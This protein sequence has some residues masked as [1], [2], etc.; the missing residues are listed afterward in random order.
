MK[1]LANIKTRPLNKEEF[2]LIIKTIREGFVLP[3]NTRVKPNCRISN[4]L[5][6]EGSLGM[7]IGDVLR[8]KLENIIWDGDKYRLNI[9][10]EKTGKK[11]TFPVPTDFYIYLQNY[12]LQ[13]GIKPNQRLFNLTVR[14]VQHHLSL[15]C[16]Y[17]GL[18]GISTHSF[19]KYFSMSVY[20]NSNHNLELVRQLLMH[21]NC[22]ITT[23]Y[24]NISSKE[25]EDALN[26]H[27]T[28][29]A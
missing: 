7:R 3:G 13:N 5:F 1:K 23:A 29:P 10:E 6:V 18:S 9:T 22:A 26:N 24:L 16:K 2:N 28:I 15:T 27:I 4:C 11:R 19:R 14:A 17:L 20:L 8:M 21:S 12:A 25:I